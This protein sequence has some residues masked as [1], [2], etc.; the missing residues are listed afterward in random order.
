VFVTFI[1]LPFARFK[2]KRGGGAEAEN[3]KQLFTVDGFNSDPS[4]PVDK[5]VVDTLRNHIASRDQKLRKKTGDP[6]KIAEYLA[7]YIIKIA[8]HFPPNFTHE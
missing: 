2:E 7:S 5:V 8:E 3:N 6:A 4:V 1:N